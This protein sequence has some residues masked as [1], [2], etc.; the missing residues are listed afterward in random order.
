MFDLTAIHPFPDSNGKVA[1]V[2]GDLFLL[3]QGL[4]PPY[5]AKYRGSNKQELYAQAERYE[6]DS[7]RDLSDLYPVVLRLYEECGQGLGGGCQHHENAADD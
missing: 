2:L 5:F 4:H 6:L 3:K 7:K 1:L